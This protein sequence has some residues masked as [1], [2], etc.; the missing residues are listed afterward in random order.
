[1]AASRVLA[2]RADRG[3]LSQSQ[4]REGFNAAWMLM[5]QHARDE[6]IYRLTALQAAREADA[7]AWTKFNTTAVGLDSAEPRPPVREVERLGK[8]RPD[9]LGRREQ[10][11]RGPYDRH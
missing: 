10:L 3:E 6:A 8:E 4:L 7:E 1:M 11:S 2:E 9:V 5:V